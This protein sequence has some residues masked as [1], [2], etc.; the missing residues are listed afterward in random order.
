MSRVIDVRNDG[1]DLVVLGKAVV[2][3]ASST[4]GPD[5]PLDGSIRFNPDTL[6]AEVY[7]LAA[8]TPL[9]TG[10]H[11]HTMDQVLGLA[12]ALSEKAAVSHTHIIAD[13]AGLQ[14]A[15]DGKASSS[16]VHN[17]SD[18]LDL[19]TNLDTLTTAVSGKANTSHTHTIVNVTGLQ[20]AL[21]LKAQ[22]VHTHQ[23]SDVIGLQ[24][25]VDVNSKWMFNFCISGRPADTMKYIISPAQ[26]VDIPNNFNG[27]ICKVGTAPTSSFSIAVTRN[28]ASAGSI[29]V[30]TDSSVTFTTTSSS[31]IT[32][33]PGDILLLQFPAQD[34]TLDTIALSILGVRS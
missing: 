11:T 13:V 16:H 5:L 1:G 34:A 30:G 22:S 6:V 31:G 21:D 4:D 17:I 26:R 3:P 33:M 19:Q 25:K 20:T 29:V 12:T 10:V 9:G 27:S 7:A 32:L 8:W 15:L 18:V 2:L 24:T 28:G 14:A 23:I